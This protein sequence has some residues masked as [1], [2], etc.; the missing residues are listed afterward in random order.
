MELYSAVGWTAYT[1]D[2]QRLVL[3]VAN[4]TYVA[5]LRADGRLVGLVRGMSDEVSVFYLQDII[6]HP[7]HQEQ[8]HG[9]D[10]LDH[11]LNRFAKV[12]QNV[13]LTDVEDRQH[14][15]YRSA[16]FRDVAEVE[17][18]HAFVRFEKP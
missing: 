2:P 6:V 13:L 12:R 4:S 16:G 9:K 3:A 11:I 7:D 17:S 14:R 15:L 10:L 8:G 1:K 18:L 5:C